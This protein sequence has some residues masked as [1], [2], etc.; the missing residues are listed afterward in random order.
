LV[1]EPIEIMHLSKLCN[2]GTTFSCLKQEDLQR[3]NSKI[4]KMLREEKKVRN[5]RIKILLLGCG[6]AGKSTFIKQMRIIHSQSGQI[7]TQQ[8]LVQ[9]RKDVLRNIIQCLQI[10][11][12]NA[13][14]PTGLA[15]TARVI[16]ELSPDNETDQGKLYQHRKFID[17]IWADESVQEV[18]K[19]RGNIN[20]PDGCKYFLTNLE[21]LT[22]PGYEPTN[23]DILQIR[24]MTTGVVE[25][26][27]KM[28]S[29]GH[30][31]KEILMIDVGGQRSERRKWI[32]C[33]DDVLLL[34]FLCAVSEYDQALLEDPSQ[35]RMEES[36]NLFKI[37]VKEPSFRNS[38]IALFFN[39][40]DLMEEKI[41]YSSL[42]THFPEFIN[43][44][45]YKQNDYTSA[46]SFIQDMFLNMKDKNGLYII[47]TKVTP[48]FCHYTCA[49]DTQNIKTVFKD[50]KVTI[51]EKTFNNIV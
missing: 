49:T 40:K 11:I 13:D 26:S 18:Y 9:H 37:L 28:K 41:R 7:W 35:N 22:S 50:V 17:E 42:E 1:T 21:R 3:T 5:N 32:H 20:L 51:L 29:H 19:K 15:N 43:F 34:M 36:R 6:E 24:V 10:L 27:F 46:V 25:Y 45:G 38:S 33:F 4:E 47:D 44:K 39:K 16:Q 12:E 14:L 2:D 30:P 23:Q 8:Q 48:V 31:T